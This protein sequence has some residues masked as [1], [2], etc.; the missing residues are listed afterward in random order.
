MS[1]YQDEEW[2]DRTRD[3]QKHE[4][5][6]I[7]VI[8]NDVR[9]LLDYAY[10]ELCLGRHSAQGT[11]PKDA[12]FQR[13]LNTTRTY[14]IGDSNREQSDRLHWMTLGEKEG[15]GLPHDEVTYLRAKLKQTEEEGI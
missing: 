10:R 6:L 15:L 1:K 7:R 5:A 4:R 11:H 2:G 3:E 13:V 9:E 12:E 14:D 8:P